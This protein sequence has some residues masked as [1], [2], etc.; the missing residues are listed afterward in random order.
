MVVP[1]RRTGFRRY[2]T[3]PAAGRRIPSTFDALSFFVPDT[4]NKRDA[5]EGIKGRKKRVPGDVV[6]QAVVHARNAA[7]NSCNGVKRFGYSVRVRRRL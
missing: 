4:L 5:V 3:V 1:V 7:F 6:E 2:R